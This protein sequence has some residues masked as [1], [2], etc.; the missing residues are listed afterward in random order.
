M[1][2]ELASTDEPE[3]SAASDVPATERRHPGSICLDDMSS[4]ELLQLLNA[5]DRGAVDAVSA[6]LPALSGLVD[7]AIARVRRGGTVHYYGAGTSGRLGILDAAELLPTFNI[8]PNLVQ[9]HIAGG[10][11]AIVTAIENSEDSLADGRADADTLTADDLAIGLTASGTTPYVAGMLERARE[12]GAY[13]ALITSNP[14]SPLRGLAD[15]VVA[16]DTGPEVLTGSTRLKAGTAEKVILNGFSTVLMVNLGRTYSN[17][18][19]SMIATN[20]KLRGRTLRI[21]GE[22]SGVDA[23]RNAELLDAADGD[24]KLAIVTLL[25]SASPDRAREALEG[26]GGSVRGALGSLAAAT[27]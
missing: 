5:E 4:L 9:A 14:A 13:T 17:L 23:A 21:L 16:P 19:V 6:V 10:A 7:E 22:I 20:N 2:T 26:A 18:M 27:D 24:L 11:K 12:R 8:E 1:N 3:H 25:S 15:I